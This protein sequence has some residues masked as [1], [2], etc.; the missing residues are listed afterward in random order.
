MR[1]AFGLWIVLPIGKLANRCGAVYDCEHFGDDFDFYSLTDLDQQENLRFLGEAG[2]TSTTRRSTSPYTSTTFTSTTSSARSVT[3]LSPASHTTT[4]TVEPTLNRYTHVEELNH[5]IP[6]HRQWT[7]LDHHGARQTPSTL[8]PSASS[9]VNYFTHDPVHWA[10]DDFAHD[11]LTDTPAH[12]VVPHAVP[13]NGVTDIPPGHRPKNPLRGSVP[14]LPIDV[15]AESP[16]SSPS[17]RDAPNHFDERTASYVRKRLKSTAPDLSQKIPTIAQKDGI[18]HIHR[19]VHPP[20][21]SLPPNPIDHV[22]GESSSNSLSG[23][24]ALNHFDE[25]THSKQDEINHIPMYP[26]KPN[27]MKPYQLVFDQSVFQV[28]SDELSKIFGIP[29]I[30]EGLIRTHFDRNSDPPVLMIENGHTNAFMQDYQFYQKK[31]RTQARESSALSSIYKPSD[32]LVVGLQKLDFNSK[33]WT[34]FYKQ[35][36]GAVQLP[37]ARREVRDRLKRVLLSYVFF[38]DIIIT[39]LRNPS[40]KLLDRNQVFGRALIFFEAYTKQSMPLH[41]IWD[42]PTNRGEYAWKYIEN[43]MVQDPDYMFSEIHFDGKLNT[44]WKGVFNSIFAYSIDG[45]T[46]RI[47]LWY[48]RRRLSGTI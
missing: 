27:K 1:I 43:W 47:N 38:I 15:D 10:P 39:I 33:V 31:L 9:P 41:T 20:H 21:G 40:G 17:G 3:P 44:V 37:L 12:G 26:E 11:W 8:F 34:A 5:L 6:D 42:G 35:R 32:L 36:L 48:S 29:K 18:N 24:I 25:N 19:V 2:S 16:P 28:T 45:F 23:N 22:N 7:H 14:T 13:A 30:M 4:T 46:K